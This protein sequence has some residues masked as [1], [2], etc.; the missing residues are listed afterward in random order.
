MNNELRKKVKLLK[1]FQGISYKELS[2]YLDIKANSLYNW[3][4]CQYDLSDEKQEQL[5]S[6]ISN[7]ME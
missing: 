5:K 4:R 6:I 3:L 7:L 2:T 1:A